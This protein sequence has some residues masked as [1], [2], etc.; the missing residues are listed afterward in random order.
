M[1]DKIAV[2][3]LRTSGISKKF[4]GKIASS[5]GWISANCS[6]FVWAA[7]GLEIKTDTTKKIIVSFFFIN[8]FAHPV[9]T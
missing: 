1:V 7:A 4:A 9:G 2:R 6:G 5:L 3:S 8:D